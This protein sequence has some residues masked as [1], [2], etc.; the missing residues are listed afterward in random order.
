ML[1]WLLSGVVLGFIGGWCIGYVMYS[2]KF[3]R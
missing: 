3:D 1:A 2:P